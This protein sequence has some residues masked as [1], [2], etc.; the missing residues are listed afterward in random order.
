MAKIFVRW[1]E[2]F[3]VDG[4][5]D[6]KPF[7]EAW[8]WSQLELGA[9]LQA[10][11]AQGYPIMSYPDRPDLLFL[12]E[13]RPLFNLPRR[14]NFK[15]VW[16]V[17][18]YGA[19]GPIIP[20]FSS[21][22]ELEICSKT[23]ITVFKMDRSRR[24]N[25]FFQGIQRLRRGPTSP[26]SSE[27]SQAPA[28]PT[29]PILIKPIPIHQRPLAIHP[30]DASP[31]FSSIPPEIRDSIF[32]YALTE[33]NKTD[34][35]SQYAQSSNYTR[36]GYTAKRTLTIGLLVTCRRIYRETYHLPPVTKEHVFWH[37]RWPPEAN[38]RHYYLH[39][40][41]QETSHFQRMQ[42]WQ[43]DLVKEVHLFTQM[44][45]LEGTFP[46]L[47]G[48]P[49]MQGIKKVKITI[50]RG[51]WWDNEIN[52]ALCIDPHNNNSQNVSA[53]HRD[54]ARE[55]NG[56]VLKWDKTAWGFAFAKL[57]SLKEVEIELETSDDKK[58]ELMA[59]VEKAK[60]WRFP[61]R[62]GTALSTKGLP[63]KINAWQ[64]SMCYW[65][66]LCP[67]CGWGEKCPVVDP[68][69][70]GCEERKRLRAEGKGPLCH[71]VSLRWRV[72]NAEEERS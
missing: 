47:C 33:Y 28:S 58:D 64:S 15:A 46:R 12:P 30:Q 40:Y 21:H 71:V 32:K 9:L 52:K 63:E 4:I 20:D 56:E 66:D 13:V 54:W 67:Y 11:S 14:T 39:G 29:R 68:P 41:Q 45:W 2:C 26:T 70:K 1:A 59:I 42:N 51:D 5:L 69:N 31:L 61:M 55:K 34:P 48:E 19:G 37:G 10:T 49:M 23:S 16:P 36:P 8:L 65:S 3:L 24:S 50:R 38:G 18:L 72:I 17:S 22:Y 7:G 6:V 35:D 53:V 57:K 44:F 60:T 25:P 62:D 43:K 27:P